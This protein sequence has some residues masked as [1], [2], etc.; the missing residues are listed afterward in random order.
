MKSIILESWD[1]GVYE[2]E[3][4]DVLRL[5]SFFLSQL[6]QWWLKSHK[7]FMSIWV[8][9]GMIFCNE[10]TVTDVLCNFLHLKDTDDKEL[11]QHF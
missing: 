9:L 6:Q 4:D 8:A 5:F 1:C 7:I 3:R 11:G 2:R 10:S